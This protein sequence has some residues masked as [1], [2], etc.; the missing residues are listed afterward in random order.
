MKED[1]RTIE[2]QV[3]QGDQ[4]MTLVL[5][6]AE[7]VASAPTPSNGKAAVQSSQ[8]KQRAGLVAWWKLDNDVADR[9]GVCP[10]AVRGNPTYVPGKSGRAISFDGDDCVDLGK[11]NLLDFAT[12]DWAVSAW[13]RT[14]QSGTEVAS[15]GTVFANGAD[16]AGGIRYTLAVNEAVSGRLTL[17]TDDDFTKLQVTGRTAIN[18]GAWHHVIATRA[19]KMLHLY[20]DGVLDASGSTPAGYSL[21]GASQQNAFIGAILDNRDQSLYKQFVGEIDEVCV[22]AMALGDRQAKA[23]CAGGDPMTIAEEAAAAPAQTSGSPPPG[24]EG[25]RG[26]ALMMLVLVLAL[27]AVIGGVVLFLVKSNGR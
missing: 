14:T 15:K 4:A 11:S 21:A 3:R 8:V 9:L 23:L 20:V 2:G 25:G 27:T 22:F 24:R 18:D 19:G 6:R 16:E 7:I 5:T 12:D 17:T 1:G 13:I 10:G 26:R